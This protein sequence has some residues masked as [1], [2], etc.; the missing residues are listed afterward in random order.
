M[1]GLLHVHRSLPR[2]KQTAVLNT[3]LADTTRSSLLQ[4][5]KAQHDQ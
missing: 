4:N 3:E 1:V 2:L 5:N